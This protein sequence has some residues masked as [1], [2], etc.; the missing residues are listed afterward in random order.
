M[1]RGFS[2]S[3]LPTMG[4]DFAVV[5]KNREGQ[6]I[7]L[8][9]W[10]LAGQP[11]FEL[12]IPRFISN[13]SGAIFVFDLTRRETFVNLAKWIK[14]FKEIN[15]KKLK[16]IPLYIV[17]NKSDLEDW[18]VKQQEVDDYAE[19]VTQKLDLNEVEVKTYLT[20]A[21]NGENINELFEHAVDTLIN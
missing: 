11:S 18:E 4:C 14:K 6:S 16:N 19:Y 8:Q 12:L 21:K 9:I 5:N 2:T 3:Y 1:G 15:E 13:S 20:S 17:G 10:D 7:E